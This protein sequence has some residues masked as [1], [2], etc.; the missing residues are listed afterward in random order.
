MKEYGK[1]DGP[2]G[3]VQDNNMSIGASDA[4]LLAV[5][6][7]GFCM[8]AWS[9]YS[10]VLAKLKTAEE[11]RQEAEEREISYEER[12]AK[13]DV[14]TLNRAQRRARA[15]HIMKQQRR[16]AGADGEMID[17]PLHQEQQLVAPQQQQQQQHQQQQHDE[18]VP[19]FHGDSHHANTQHLL[20]RKE[21]QKAAKQ[22]ELQE[23][24][25]LEEDRR[26]EQKKAQEAAKARR[27]T[28]ELHKTLQMERERKERR[29]QQ[30][31]DELANYRAWKIFLEN[32]KSIRNNHDENGDGQNQSNTI[33]V[34]EWIGELKENRIVYLSDLADRFEVDESAVH[35][36]IQELL[37]TSRLCG[38]LEKDDGDDES[39]NYARFLYISANEMSEL[40][41]FVKS[42]DQIITPRGFAKHIKEHLKLQQ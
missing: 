26:N 35:D 28:K 27:K 18:H 12:L 19:A 3:K 42:Q 17:D 1:N 11:L 34:Q 31:A 29:E 30:E 9:M 38:I 24:K 21:R 41:S 10:I 6:F 22:V 7:A 4:V 23:R 39:S 15:K 16:L 14:S 36:R 40:A 13:A 37:D 25:L 20:S 8:L 2:L 5:S 33:T 32:E